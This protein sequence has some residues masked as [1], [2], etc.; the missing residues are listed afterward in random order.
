MITLPIF[1]VAL[2]AGVQFL[3]YA[4]DGAAPAY[5]VRS[6]RF[7]HIEHS[8]SLRM[9]ASLLIILSHFVL[10][11]V[12]EKTLMDLVLFT[13]WFHRV[14]YTDRSSSVVSYDIDSYELATGT[15]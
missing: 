1:E 15:A 8:I 5:F 10:Y 13:L 11:K 4:A 9:H 7:A 6:L 12:S 14:I 2:L 3:L